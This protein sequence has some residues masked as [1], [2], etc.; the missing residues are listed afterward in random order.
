MLPRASGASAPFQGPFFTGSTVQQPFFSASPSLMAATFSPATPPTNSVRLVPSSSQQQQQQLQPAILSPPLVAPSM[1]APHEEQFV[2]P[3][4][5]FPHA[6]PTPPPPSATPPLHSPLQPHGVFNSPTNFSGSPVAANPQGHMA[7][8]EQAFG[9][10]PSPYFEM[11]SD[12]MKEP[13]ANMTETTMDIGAPQVPL[14]FPLKPEPQLDARADDLQ[15]QTCLREQPP[16]FTPENLG[17]FQPPPS[18]L[19]STPTQ[20]HPPSITPGRSPIPLG[21]ASSYVDLNGSSPAPLYPC[22]PPASLSDS[23]QQT[24]PLQAGVNAVYAQLFGADAPSMSP[25][26]APTPTL[27]PTPLTHMA[28]SVSPEQLGFGAAS[29]DSAS[30]PAMNGAFNFPSP[31]RQQRQ[32]SFD[33]SHSGDTPSPTVQSRREMPPPS[34]FPFVRVSSTGSLGG[35]ASV[36]PPLERG[37][38]EPTRHLQDQVRK[39]TEQNEHQLREIEKHQSLA[40]KQYAEL[41]QHY[42][43]QTAGKTS[44]QQQHLLQS[45]ID[46]PSVLG[47]LRS[48]L[49]S[50]QEPVGGLE[51]SAAAQ[52]TVPAATPMPGPVGVA[53]GSA[54]AP[55]AP[56]LKL[57]SSPQKSV[58][59]SPSPQPPN[60]LMSPTQLSKVR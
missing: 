16:L 32:S 22:I 21:E 8:T 42:L 14:N 52:G 37:R 7:P 33:S 35:G 24:K 10:P 9:F 53:E 25:Q 5:I 23:H 46:D 12:Q 36:R 19:P 26:A 3:A 40:Q 11:P 41:L 1:T 39:L 47:I 38:S 18:Q 4:D 29:S 54:T 44:E 2:A 27:S 58:G 30:Q 28:H 15:M 43:L 48:L 59:S 45:V 34:S 17:P 6:S 20:P 57:E 13:E 56:L 31:F 55:V 60:P 50:V 49:M 51:G